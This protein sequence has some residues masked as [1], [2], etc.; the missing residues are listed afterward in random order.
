MPRSNQSESALAEQKS[1]DSDPITEG[2]RDYLKRV[3]RVAQEVYASGMGSAHTKAPMTQVVASG[4][5]VGALFIVAPV[6]LTVIGGVTVL[7][8]MLSDRKRK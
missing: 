8:H 5:T 3:G 1:D 2:T 4:V 6:V 7:G